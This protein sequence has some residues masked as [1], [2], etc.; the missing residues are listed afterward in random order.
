MAKPEITRFV[1]DDFWINSDLVCVDDFWVGSD[2]VFVNDFWV[3]NKLC[4]MA[5]PASAAELE[6]VDDF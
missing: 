3:D 2:T 6:R 5:I 1:A 4:T